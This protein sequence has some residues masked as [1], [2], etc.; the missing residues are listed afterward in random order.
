MSRILRKFNIGA[1]IYPYRTIENILP[2]LKDFVDAIYKRGAIYKIYCKDC[3]GVCIGK[4]GRCFNTR[5]SEHKRD[6]NRLIWL[7]KMS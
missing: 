7:K 4:K 2:K 3:S 1:Y 5:L 6:L